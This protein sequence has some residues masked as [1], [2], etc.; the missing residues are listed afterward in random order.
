VMPKCLRF[1]YANTAPKSIVGVL[2]LLRHF[3]SKGDVLEFDLNPN[4]FVKGALLNNG[5]V[6]FKDSKVVDDLLS[7]APLKVDGLLI[8]L[9]KNR[10][11]W[12][13]ETQRRPTRDP[14]RFRDEKSLHIEQLATSMRGFFPIID[15]K[16][17]PSTDEQPKQL[18][19]SG[20]QPAAF[21]NDRSLGKETES[22]KVHRSESKDVNA[23]EEDKDEDNPPQNGS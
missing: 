7:Q 23:Q 6:V 1:A 5:H 19:G 16:E 4:K 8:N 9:E 10:N 2:P 20:G 18:E 15:S 3:R 14:K 13:Y 12:S 21:A 11:V 17:V 22:Y